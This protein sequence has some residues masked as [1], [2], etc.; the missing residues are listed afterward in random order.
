MVPL[1]TE[2]SDIFVHVASYA[3]ITNYPEGEAGPDSAFFR[4]YF[5]DLVFDNLALLEEHWE[6]IMGSIYHTTTDL[7]RLNEMDPVEIQIRS[8]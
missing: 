4:K 5:F 1:D 6:R 2:F 7:A 3:D 8:F